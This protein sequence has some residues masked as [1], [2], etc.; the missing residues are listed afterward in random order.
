MTMPHGRSSVVRRS[1]CL[2]AG[3]GSQSNCVSR[4][5]FTMQQY[6][7]ALYR[8]SGWSSRGS[9]GYVT[10][11]FVQSQCRWHDVA[12]LRGVASGCVGCAVRIRLCLLC[13]APTSPFQSIVITL[14]HPESP[15]QS[16]RAGECVRTQTLISDPVQ[17]TTF[18]KYNSCNC[19][20]TIFMMQ[21]Y[22]AS[23]ISWVG[24][25]RALSSLATVCAGGTP[26][27]KG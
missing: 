27:L 6:S 17:R 21:L 16:I 23:S 1:T 14:G 2:S 3:T 5:R 22:R 19:N 13:D 7:S 8:H 11:P 25:P 12:L 20:I 24:L 26:Y 9:M 15:S 4:L 10:M 18:E